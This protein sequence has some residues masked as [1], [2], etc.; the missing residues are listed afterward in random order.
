MV[1]LAI[2]IADA[3]RKRVSS[4]SLR[5]AVPSATF[6]V[7]TDK[8]LVCEPAMANLSQSWVRTYNEAVESD[9]EKLQERVLEAERAILSRWQELTDSPRGSAEMDALER[10]CH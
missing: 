5:R 9:F 8:S 7:P 10:A 6:A 4:H 2:G 1:V 3:Y